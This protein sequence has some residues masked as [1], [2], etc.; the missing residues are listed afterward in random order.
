MSCVRVCVHVHEYDSIYTCACPCACAHH[1]FAGT[2][3]RLGTCKRRDTRMPQPRV[4]S[5]RNGTSPHVCLAAAPHRRPVVGLVSMRAREVP[6][7][8]P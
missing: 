5:V 6:V 7:Y 8:S 3:A 4:Q 2:N 1:G